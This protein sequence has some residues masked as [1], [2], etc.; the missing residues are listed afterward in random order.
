MDLETAMEMVG[1]LIEASRRDPCDPATVER[2][3]DTYW[4]VIDALRRG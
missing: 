1:D 2:Y 4:R 3:A